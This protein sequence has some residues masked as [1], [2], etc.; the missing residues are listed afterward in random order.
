MTK[1]SNAKARQFVQD[2]KEFTGSNTF[3]RWNNGHYVVYSYGLHFPLFVWNAYDH[4]WYKNSD[5]YS[6]TTSK[7]SNQ[8]HPLGA[9]YELN[10]NQL[11]QLINRKYA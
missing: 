7:H 9:V 5:K 11:N 8:L 10:T 2:K 3:G 6:V 4:Q 1:T